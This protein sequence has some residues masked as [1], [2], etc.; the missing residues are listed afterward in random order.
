MMRQK[1]EL[2]QEL[3]RLTHRNNELKTLLA[4]LYEDKIK[5]GI[6][7]DIFLLLANEFKGEQER[8]IK[9]CQEIQETIQQNH[10]L[11]LSMDNFKGVVREH[12]EIEQLTKELLY[13][14][15]ERIDIYQRNGNREA[16]TLYHIGTLNDFKT[17][18]NLKS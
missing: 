1:E 6:A 8:N 10:Y 3:H 18:I 2:R 5:G 12:K 14:F 16:Y 13:Q 9:N 11:K 15:I 17:V 4:R 7:D